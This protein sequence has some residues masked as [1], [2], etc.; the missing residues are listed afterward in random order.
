VCVCHIYTCILYKTLVLV[1]Q[2]CSQGE[3][4]SLREQIN[5]QGDC[6]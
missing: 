2:P 1:N 4:L 5:S 6:R 3:S